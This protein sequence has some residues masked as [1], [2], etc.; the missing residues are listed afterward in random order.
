[1]FLNLLENFKSLI[2]KKKIQ[3]NVLIERYELGLGKLKEAEDNVSEMKV[4]L[5]ELGPK[6]E[7]MKEES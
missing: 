6:L 5:I 1:M 7:V 2:Q 4:I 3:N